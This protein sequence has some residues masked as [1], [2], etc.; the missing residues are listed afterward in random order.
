MNVTQYLKIDC[1]NI[2]INI[3]VQITGSNEVLFIN[4]YA[5]W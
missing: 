3:L 5:D 2:F 1:Y 4:F